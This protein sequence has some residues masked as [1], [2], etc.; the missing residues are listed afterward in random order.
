MHIL[1]GSFSNLLEEANLGENI[2]I[3]KNR[4][5]KGKSGSVQIWESFNKLNCSFWQNSVFSIK[6]TK[7]WGFFTN[8]TKN[9]SFP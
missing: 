7:N 4:V 1:S 3:W 9:A 2:V 8:L 6:M 5:L